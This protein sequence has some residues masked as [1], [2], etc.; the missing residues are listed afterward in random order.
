MTNNEQSKDIDVTA[1]DI[2]TGQSV[3]IGTVKKGETKTAILDTQEKTLADGSVNFYYTWSDGS[4]GQDALKADYEGVS[5]CP[6]PSPTPPPYCPADPTIKEAVCRWDADENATGYEVEVIE[7][8]SGDIIKSETVQHPTS[9][10]KFEFDPEK[11][12]KCS[13]KSVNPCGT[14]EPGES[15]P[16]NCPRITPTPTGPW[17]PDE[18]DTKAR[19]VWDTLDGAVKYNVK[20]KDAQT[21]ETIYSETVDHPKNSLEFERE[22]I[23]TYICTVEPENACGTGDGSDSPPVSCGSPTPTVSIPP[24]VTIP[25]TITPTVSPSWIPIPTVSP[26]PTGIPTPTTPPSLTPTRTPTPTKAPT[27]TFTPSPTPTI[28]PT[29]TNTPTPTITPTPT[30]TPTLAPTRTPTPTRLPPGAHT[31]TP[32]MEPTGVFETTV[33]ALGVAI[34]ITIAGALMFLL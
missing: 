11:T 23:N 17:C 18:P 9:Q 28:T 21:G 4:P 2:Q 16:K 24:S 8:G 27:P 10:L 15:A 34:V 33:F 25:P 3:E 20:I 32:T 1:T 12:Y 7:A 6:E 29:P 30:N 14:S 13:V 5:E 19:C 31:P 26:T 22:G